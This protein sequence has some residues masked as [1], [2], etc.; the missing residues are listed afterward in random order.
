MAFYCSLSAFGK[1]L[2]LE[3]AAEILAGILEEER[4]LTK[5]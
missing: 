3:D 4:T 2:G 5:H 1:L